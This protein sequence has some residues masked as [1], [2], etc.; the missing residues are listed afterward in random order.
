MRHLTEEQLWA[1][2]DEVLSPGEIQEVKNHLDN[3]GDCR[4]QLDGL[5]QIDAE[6]PE[7]II[8]E[9][10]MRF[11]QN[12]M[13]A[14]ELEVKA[15]EYPPLVGLIWQRLYGMGLAFM[16]IGGLFFI[17]M[18]RFNLTL[19]ETAGQMSQYAAQWTSHPLMT[20]FLII[21]LVLWALFFAD[22]ILSRRML[23]RG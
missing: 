4:L 2:L 16:I 18:N 19:P 3:C 15:R 12:V 22:R 5:R 13:E 14:V 20:T 17:Y 1:Y 8:S 7:V 21:P 9:P 23:G 10:S 6:M 11:T